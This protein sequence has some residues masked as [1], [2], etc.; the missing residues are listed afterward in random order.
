MI[1]VK[2]AFIGS[3]YRG[4]RKRS[5]QEIFYRISEY[6]VQRFCQETFCRNVCRDLAKRSLTEILPI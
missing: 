3:L 5:Y 6:L 4:L 1:P 2:R